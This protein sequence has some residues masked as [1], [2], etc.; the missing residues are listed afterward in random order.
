VAVNKQMTMLPV[1]IVVAV[2]AVAGYVTLIPVYG[3]WAGAWLTVASETAV[4]VAAT[5]IALKA[6]PRG[7][8][9]N[10]LLKS[11]FA[12]A[13]MALAILP[14][15]DLWLPIPILTGMIVYTVLVVV[16]GA[17]SKGTLQEILS[18]RRGEAPTEIL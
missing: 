14:V 13:V 7:F 8:A 12:S 15:R 5:W 17:I 16:T 6:S 18:M 3:M 10:V 4:A 1:Y 9:W 11:L 2:L